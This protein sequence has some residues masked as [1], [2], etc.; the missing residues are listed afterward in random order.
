MNAPI[1]LPEIFK[2]VDGLPGNLTTNTGK[3]SDCISLK[4]ANRCTVI[5]ELTQ[6][7]G[8]ATQ[9]VLRQ[10]TVVAASDAKVLT[11]VV[12][13]WANE[14]CAASDTLVRQTDAVNY[15]VT[16][17]V[18]KKLIVFQVEPGDFDIANG[19][20][21]LDLTIADSSQATNFANVLF[22]VESKYA[23]ATPPAVITD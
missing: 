7:V 3:T 8:H 13:I 11:N 5:V 9:I 2:L 16:N 1:T 23:Q 6:A 21:C 15:T 18:K 14:D 10:S 20:D 17:D 19:F 22:I 4:T 12:P